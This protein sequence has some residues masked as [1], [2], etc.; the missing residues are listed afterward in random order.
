MVLGNGNNPETQLN[1][2][3]STCYYFE[4]VINSVFLQPFLFDYSA[5]LWWVVMS[6]YIEN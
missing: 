1:F 6:L 2:A 4:L 5:V 3:H